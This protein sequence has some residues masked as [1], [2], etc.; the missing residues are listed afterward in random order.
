MGRSDFAEMPGQGGGGLLFCGKLGVCPV[1]G[2]CKHDNTR[3]R[4]Q[5]LE[6]GENLT[7]RLRSGEVKPE[8]HEIERVYAEADC[9]FTAAEVAAALDRIASAI[10]ARLAAANPVVLCVM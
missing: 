6:K 3:H 8:M 9:L 2:R 10:T 5:Y 7:L 1:Q 4:G